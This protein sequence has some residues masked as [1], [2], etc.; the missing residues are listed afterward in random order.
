MAMHWPV[1]STMSR[2]GVLLALRWGLPLFGFLLVAVLWVAGLALMDVDRQRTEALAFS[3]SEASTQAFEAHVARRLDQISQ[4]ASF[5]ALN[6]ESDST[7]PALARLVRQ[8]LNNQPDLKSLYLLD[9][10]GKLL[11][12]ALDQV[13]T[14]N[15]TQSAA[16]R[17]YFQVHRDKKVDGLYVGAP[18]LGRVSQTWVLHLSLARKKPDGSFAGVVV[19][20]V[21]PAFLANFYS[22]AQFGK[23]GLVSL[24][25]LDDWVVRARRSGDRVWFGERA[26]NNFLVE[27]VNKAP[28][29]VYFTPSKLDN[30]NR[31]MAYRVM[32]QYRLVA[33]TGLA[34]DEV[35]AGY[36]QRRSKLMDFL[37]ASTLVVLLASLAFSI[38]VERLQLSRWRAADAESRF[39]AA[40]DAQLDAFFIFSAVSA[41]GAESAERTRGEEGSP[42]PDFVCEHANPRALKW[43]GRRREQ[44][45]G[46]SALAMVPKAVRPGLRA[47]YQKVLTTRTPLEEEFT[48]VTRRGVQMQVVQQV[49][50]LGGG[51]AVTMRDVTHDR[52][53]EG[54]LKQQKL[55]L[56]ASQR[57]LSAITNNV[58]A[59]ISY[60][61]ANHKVMFTNETYTQWFGQ[62]ASSILGTHLKDHWSPSLYA[63]LIPFVHRA[64]AGQR[65]EFI[66]ERET[67]RGL[68]VMQN[69][70]VP[71]V[72]SEGVVRGIF[73]LAADITD[74]KRTE[75]E[76][77]QLLH[78]DALTGLDNRL[79]VNAHLPK[80]IAR[81]KRAG[82]GIALLFLDVDRFKTINDTHG[83]AV[84]DAVL[85]E[86]AQRLKHTVRAADMVAR[87]AG[88]E[89]VILLEALDHAKETES[90]A[91]KV[92]RQFCAPILYDD[93]ALEVTMSIGVAYDK[94]C[95]MSGEELL[96]A[97]D[98]E[99]YAAKAAGRNAF[100]VSIT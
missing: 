97:A 51:L 30:V 3:R 25:G 23:S 92:V 35:L 31:Y 69:T 73:I 42:A 90:I 79:S 34:Q 39:H 81:S 76:L 1:L 84:G 17:A 13:V 11:A 6:S 56:E 38:L 21:D 50:P 49:V 95:V 65:V 63:Q 29:G 72:T 40:S 28:A 62:P 61:D 70:Y 32:P 89:F 52:A 15:S 91:R 27:Q 54:L 96:N 53:R 22:E 78:T 37:W 57:S 98:M 19:A 5:V 83:H 14:N 93:L 18:T 74:L 80:A 33:Y 58:P 26:G 67:V 44:V 43:L 41:E 48:L 64:L 55:A 2:R 59:L 16:D 47:A 36:F 12:A 10:E 88:D 87:L 86:V 24:T 7:K 85:K 100:S 75:K 82:R 9:A 60:V 99:L 45:V 94:H 71:D 68:R 20:T 77:S 46:H 4:L 66:A 8:S